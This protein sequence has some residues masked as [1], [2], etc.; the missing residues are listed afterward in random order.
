MKRFIDFY[1][2]FHIKCFCIVDS[3]ALIEGFEK[4]V[5]SD[6]IKLEREKLLNKLDEIASVK[7]AK[8][9]LPATKIK[10]LVRRYKW[11]ERYNK[12]KELGLKVKA[13]NALT[14]EETLEIDSLF[15][16]EENNLR[17]RIFT[18]KAIEIP[19]K[20]SLLAELRNQDVFILSHGAIESYYPDGVTGDDKPTK[21]LNVVKILK[22]HDD[23]RVHLPT[24]K[25][26]EEALC[27]LEVIFK[28][29][30]NK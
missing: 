6:G 13:G 9:D 29:Y 1:S 17:R 11:K 26:G 21:A 12:L 23:C 22:E 2:F 30:L 16:E 3:D 24:I 5:V 4:F 10:E 28:R 25:V 20:S 18:D 14:E 19:E 27:E 7:G 8:A 15:I